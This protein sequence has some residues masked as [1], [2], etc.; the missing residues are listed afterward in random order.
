MHGSLEYY[1]NDNI[2]TLIMGEKTVIA[3]YTCKDNLTP[4]LYSGGKKKYYSAIRVKSCHLQQPG[5]AEE[6]EYHAI[7]LRCESKKQKKG[8]SRRG[9]VVNESD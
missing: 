1:S 2:K 9:A 3:M 7:S 8:S 6:G 5:W 4:L